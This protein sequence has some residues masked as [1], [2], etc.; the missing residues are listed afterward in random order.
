MYHNTMQ[1]MTL[2]FTYPVKIVITENI[3]VENIVIAG[4]FKIGY[5]VGHRKPFRCDFHLHTSS[6][7]NL[8]TQSPRPQHGQERAL[9]EG[10]R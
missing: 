10:V 8:A 1:M 7:I 3:L 9:P 4:V 5:L 2:S 6:T